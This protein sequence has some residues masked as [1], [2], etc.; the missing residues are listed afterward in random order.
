V[1]KVDLPLDWSKLLGFDQAKPGTDVLKNAAKIGSKPCE[2][3]R[4]FSAPLPTRE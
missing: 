2:S 3:Y 4:A 1:S